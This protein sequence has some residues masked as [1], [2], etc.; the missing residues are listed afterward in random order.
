MGGRMASLV[1]RR[2][3]ELSQRTPTAHE[4]SNLLVG[5]LEEV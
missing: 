1:N 2:K 5:T 4:S 3:T